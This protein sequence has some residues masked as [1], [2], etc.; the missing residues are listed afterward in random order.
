[1]IRVALCERDR[2]ERERIC[3]MLDRYQLSTEVAEYDASETLLWDMETDGARYDLYF[4]PSGGGEVSERIRGIDGDALFIFLSGG[5]AR[6][7]E[8]ADGCTLGSV[9][10][11]VEEKA[12]RTLLEKAAERLRRYKRRV[13]VITQRSRTRVLR[14]DDIEY[15]SSANHILRFYLRGGEEQ[16]CY[17]RLDQAVPQLDPETFVRCHQS[18]IVNLKC[19]AGHSPKAFHM[20]SGA[21]IPISRSYAVPVRKAVEEYLFRCK[22]FDPA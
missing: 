1:M 2:E 20:T 4:L 7:R 6:R 12:L 10:K 18:H 22:S 17:G 16:T 14:F 9:E 8:E 11:P 3:S 15:V 5:I 19:V 21:V 13:M